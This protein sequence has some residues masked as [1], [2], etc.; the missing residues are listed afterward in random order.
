M[1]QSIDIEI[2][3]RDA[4]AMAAKLRLLANP[5]RLVMLCKLGLEEQSVNELVQL[6]GIA[7]STVSQHLAV[8]RDA[9]VVARRRQA[10]SLYYRLVDGHIF[11]MIEALCLICQAGEHPI[12]AQRVV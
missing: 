9:G 12:A 4:G 8:L 5:D 1:P 7:Q 2:L 10:Q 3:R 6:T 11:A